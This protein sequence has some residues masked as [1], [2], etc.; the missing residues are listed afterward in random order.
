MPTDFLVEQGNT[1]LE[2]ARIMAGLGRPQESTSEGRALWSCMRGQEPLRRRRGLGAARTAR[3]VIR[4]LD[5]RLGSRN[6]PLAAGVHSRGGDKIRDR[7]GAL[8][9]PSLSDPSSPCRQPAADSFGSRLVST[10][11]S[12]SYGARAKL[13]MS[14]AFL[15]RPERF[16]LPTFGSVAARSVRRRTKRAGLDQSA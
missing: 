6:A 1:R 16:E 7:R 14:G 9:R 2:L 5:L 8:P 13:H 15:A 4:L 3:L 11:L 10:V 12:H